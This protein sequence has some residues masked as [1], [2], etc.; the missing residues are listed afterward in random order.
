MENNAYFTLPESFDPLLCSLDFDQWLRKYK[1]CA[2]A[3]EWNEQDQLRHLPP[4]LKGDAWILYD[5]LQDNEKDTLQH[6]VTN[7]SKKL[8]IATQIQSAEKL[9]QRCFEPGSESLVTFQN[10]IK[11]LAHRAYP[12]MTAE[13]IKPIALTAFIR[14][15]KGH[16]LSLAR[17]VRN[18]NPH[19]L[20]AALSKAQFI[21]SD[22]FVNDDMK[23]ETQVVAINQA[24]SSYLVSEGPLE[25]HA[26]K[27]HGSPAWLPE[28][29]NAI[30]STVRVCD[31]CGRQGHTEDNCFKKQRDQGYGR[32][33][34][35]PPQRRMEYPR[36]EGALCHY[37]VKRN[38][39]EEQCETKRRAMA[40]KKSESQGN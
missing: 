2:E 32:A 29:V 39:T 33:D 1:V 9:H 7:L 13:Q 30:R 24:E 28:L 35:R 26:K 38:Q 14:G 21:L 20:Q 3:N 27:D 19:T 5:E 37:C 15:L 8:T 40:L 22:P 16:S 10:D 31:Y 17:K 25:D 34:R 11:R 6:L 4:L 18:S 12:E 36:T 23:T